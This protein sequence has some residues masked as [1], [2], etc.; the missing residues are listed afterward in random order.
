MTWRKTGTEFD[1]ECADVDMSDHA[2]RTHMEAIGYV[3]KTKARECLINKGA[4]RRFATSSRV[5]DAIQELLNVGFWR[6][7]GTHFEVVH[8]A[9]VIADSLDAQQA[10]RDRDR[11]AQQSKRARDSKKDQEPSVSGDV[12]ADTRQTDRQTDKHLGGDVKETCQHGIKHGHKSEPWS[13][14]G[15][16]VCAT[17]TAERRAS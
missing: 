7:L 1:D 8:H 12:S 9:D 13:S 14:D 2:Y 4:L 17:C 11:K 5:N 6:D 15:A 16:L 10:K 3:Y